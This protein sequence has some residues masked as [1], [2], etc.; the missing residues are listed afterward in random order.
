MFFL[1]LGGGVVG[2]HVKTLA[3][4][5]KGQEECKGKELGGGSLGG[6]VDLKTLFR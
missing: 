3:S 4:K 1:F 6:G 2:G 5:W